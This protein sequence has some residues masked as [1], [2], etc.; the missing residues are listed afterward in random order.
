MTSARAHRFDATGVAADQALHGVYVDRELSSH[1][2]EA[3]VERSHCRQCAI[4]AGH[5]DGS[6]ERYTVAYR[7]ED[8]LLACGR[9]VTDSQGT[10]EHINVFPKGMDSDP[11]IV[12]R[13][14]EHLRSYEQRHRI[15]VDTSLLRGRYCPVHG[16]SI[17]CGRASGI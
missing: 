3:L 2:A 12:D 4:G 8:E 17:R 5:M 11:R 15:G 10:F 16:V 14:L 6:V 7:S 1:E 13:L 9:L